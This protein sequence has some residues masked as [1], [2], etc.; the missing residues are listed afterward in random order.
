MWL[1]WEDSVRAFS[2]IP[3][4]VVYV[5]DVRAYIH[6]HIEDLGTL[7][8]KRMYMSDLMGESG[9]IKPTY[10]HI[11]ELGFTN[12]LDIPDFEDEIIRYVLSIV[13]G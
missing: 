2:H 7:E 1:P 6:Y 10:K 11:E 13:H 5:E 3:E 9:K 8:I 12:I 4:G